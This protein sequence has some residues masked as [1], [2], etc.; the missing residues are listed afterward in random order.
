[1]AD[2]LTQRVRAYFRAYEIGDRSLIENTMADG[3]TFTSPFDDA[4]GRAAYFARCWPNNT[5]HRRFDFE[6][7]AQ[8]GDKV[9]VVYIANMATGNPVHPT[10]TFRN[11]ECHAF[12]NG[13]LKSVTVFFGDPPGGLTRKAFAEQSGAG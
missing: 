11:A 2:D 7:I 12:E 8:D 3:F 4:I 13:R 1:M 5:N 9:L 6:A 10:A